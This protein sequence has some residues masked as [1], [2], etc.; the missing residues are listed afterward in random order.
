ML[1]R[2]SRFGAALALFIPLGTASAQLDPVN[3]V[4]IGHWDGYGGTYAD[5]WGDGTYAYVGHFG[6][7]GVHIIDISDA[8]SPGRAVEYLLPPPDTGAS[9]QDLK[10]AEGL[11]FIGIENGTSSVHVVD[12]REPLN[13]S[14]VVTIAI[15]GFS[16]VHNV[17]YDGGYLYMA[18]SS[19]TRVGIVDLTALDPDAPP[20]GPITT[21]LW[22]MQNVGNSFVHDVTVAGGRMYVSAWDSGLWIYDATNVASQMPTFLGQ[23]PDG[24]DNTHSCW[25]TDAGDYVVTGEEHQGGGIKV[26][27]ITDN[28][29]SLS[30]E[31]TAVHALPTTVASSV[32]NQVIDRY[33]LY[34]SW[35]GAGLQVFDIDPVTGLLQFVAS[36][37]TSATGGGAWGVYPLLGSARILVSDMSAGLFILHADPARGDIDH[38][39]SVNVTDLLL[40]LA[41]WGACPQPCPPTCPADLDADCQVSVTDLLILLSEWT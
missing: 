25:P 17:F 34:N 16:G 12:V 38:D 41:A 36:Y 35:Y 31:L 1:R 21:A 27:R 8:A 6:H 20:P 26:Y 29:S 24:G 32:H 11:L 30:L 19:T 9:A 4:L 15:P 23:T 39:G 14:P 3:A 37:D 33:R 7:H 40:L 5:V 2:I 28:G 22:I 13:P 18:D 10:V